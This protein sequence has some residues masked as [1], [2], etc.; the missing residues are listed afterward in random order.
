MAIKLR[1]DKLEAA[2]AP[3]AFDREGAVVLVP[4]KG[5]ARDAEAMSRGYQRI[6][7]GGETYRRMAGETQ[8]DFVQRVRVRIGP[9]QPRVLVFSYCTVDGP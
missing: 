7:C 9:T 2:L 5:G 1:V 3:V 8:D 6:E 4:A